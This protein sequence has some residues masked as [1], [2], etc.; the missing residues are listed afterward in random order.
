MATLSVSILKDIAMVG[1]PLKSKGSLVLSSESTDRSLPLDLLLVLDCS[2]SM[3]GEGIDVVTKSVNHILNDLLRDDDRVAI[4]SFNNQSKLHSDWTEKGSKIGEFIANG[5]TNFNA[6]I[7]KCIEFLGSQDNNENERAGI[8]LFLS[9]GAAQTNARDSS[10]QCITDFGYTM[11]TV[12]VTNQAIPKELE[13]MAELARG[14]YFHAPS[15]E[16][17]SNAFTSLFNLGK[18][19]VYAAP[20]LG[21][22]VSSGTR[23]LNLIQSPQGNVIT[24][25][26][27]SGNH[28]ISV[29]HLHADKRVEISFDL[30]LDNVQKGLNQLASFSFQNK[31]A[32]LTLKGTEIETEL[33]DAP[34]NQE[35]TLIAQT[36]RAAT[37][38]KSG[39][40]AAVTRAI[41]KLETLGHT[42]PVA[43]SRAENLTTVSSV[44]DIGTRLETLGKLQAS[45]SGETK[46]RRE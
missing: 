3:L 31:N 15:F 32:I 41:Q 45:V 4:I 30:E 13:K 24:G 35:V 38:T 18:T 17:V 39:D 11:H 34:I 43:T 7:E 27:N 16:D 40:Y 23:L 8:V 5:G 1:M 25:E 36:A 19:V 37:A 14:H 12:G 20:E 28:K 21:V 22:T 2:H 46:I 42:L 44:T 29:G 33:Y 26:I 6:A 9:D 10:I